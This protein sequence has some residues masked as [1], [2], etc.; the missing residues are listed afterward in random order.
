VADPFTLT[1]IV[2]T[3][4]LAGTVKGVVGMGL[5]AVS[6]ALLTALLDLPTAMALMLVPSFVTNVWQAVVGGNGLALL[7]RLA[8]F[9]ILAFAAV[10]LGGQALVTVDLSLLSAL[11]GVLLVFYGATG[12]ANYRMTV[13]AGQEGWAGPA[14]GFINGV[15]TGMTG[16][17]AFPG[18]LYLQALGL[19]RDELI[20][21][22]GILFTLSTVGVAISLQG[23]ALLT[24]ELGV[25]SAVGLVPAIL[26]MVFGQRIRQRMSEEI[27]RRVF[28]IALVFL[29]AYIGVTA[30]FRY[31][32]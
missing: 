15:F 22:M 17:F 24:A 21:A 8:V 12:L 20:Q 26:G 2:V 29:G 31:L 7:K 9:F 11:L 27:F 28:L 6:L 30:F 3:F 1:A 14:I 23:N 5:P 32:G 16:S 10:W 4:L 13:R 18:V 25:L 19:K